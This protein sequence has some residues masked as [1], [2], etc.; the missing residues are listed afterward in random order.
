MNLNKAFIVGN[1]TRD[2][3]LKSLP[4][5]NSVV[6][7]GVATNRVWTDQSGQ[8]KEEAQFHNVVA[9]GKQAESI[10]QY[11]K[12]GSMVLIEGRIQTRNWEAQD[13]SKRSRTE[14]IAERVQFGPK[15]TG[16]SSGPPNEQTK[17]EETL[18]TI[19]YPEDHNNPDEVP[20]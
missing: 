1:L 12:K 17:E 20:F 9:F 10:N 2:P 16:Q 18:D 3:E 13:G 14:I 15:R 11:L 5:G 7:F 19:E 4:S 6:N 8:K